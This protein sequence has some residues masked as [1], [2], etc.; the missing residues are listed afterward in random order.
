ME[1]R[2][3]TYAGTKIILLLLVICGI[4]VFKLLYGP[5]MGKIEKRNV[6]IAT[7]NYLNKKYGDHNYEIISIEYN[8]DKG[9]LFGY[10]NPY[11]YVVRFTSN[12]V[13]QSSLY[14]SGL[15]PKKYRF[16]DNFLHD[17]LSELY[18]NYWKIS[19]IAPVEDM[20][21]YFL[22]KIQKEFDPNC[23][24]VVIKHPK[25]V[26]PNDFGRLPTIEELENNIHFYTVDSLTFTL[27]ADVANEE[28]YEKKLKAYLEKE[29]GSSWQITVFSNGKIHCYRSYYGVS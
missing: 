2:H 3:E 25:I 23:E 20:Q 6:K 13:N 7:I 11:G 22:E 4:F 1:E 19:D 8:Y 26:I 14:V 10:T 27:S 29:F 24:T 9:I 15:T 18:S 21:T 5:F 16:R 17:Y 12:V 28:E